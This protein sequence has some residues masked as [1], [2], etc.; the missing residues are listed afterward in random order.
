[1]YLSTPGIKLLIS[2]HVQ[3]LRMILILWYWM[4]RQW[5]YVCRRSLSKY[6]AWK[7]VK[8]AWK[9]K[10]ADFLLHWEYGSDGFVS[11]PAHDT[12]AYRILFMY[13]HV[14]SVINWYETYFP[15]PVDG[16]MDS[17]VYGEVIRTWCFRVK[18][19]DTHHVWRRQKLLITFRIKA[20]RWYWVNWKSVVFNLWEK[21]INVHGMEM[22]QNGVKWKLWIKMSD[23]LSQF[24][25]PMYFVR[26]VMIHMH[27][28]CH[29]CMC[30]WELGLG[31]LIFRGRYR[32]QCYHLSSAIAR[33]AL[34]IIVPSFVWI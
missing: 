8:I 6:E 31:F 16:T 21:F 2:F 30:M 1:M 5:R 26:L 9:I 18:H 17:I 28:E 29:S 33:R 27:T 14:G 34:A 7:W 10:T 13:V 24:G 20:W 11:V 22:N 12:Y 4:W 23:F 25:T 15:C 19:H 3:G 32:V